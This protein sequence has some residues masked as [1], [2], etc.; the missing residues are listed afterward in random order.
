MP[1]SVS[2]IGL[3]LAAVIAAVTLGGTSIVPLG[4]PPLPPDETTLR[5]AP[6]E[7]VFFVASAGIGEPEDSSENHTDQLLANDQMHAFLSDFGTQVLSAAQQFGKR[8]QDTQ[9]IVDGSKPLVVA[10]LSR[11]MAAYIERID[12]APGK[13]PSLVA[14]L[15]VNCG[16]QKAEVSKALDAFEKMGL[17]AA[18]PGDKVDTATIAGVKLRTATLS[19]GMDVHWGFKGDYFIT[20]IGPNAA[21]DLLARIGGKGAKPRWMTA[22]EK[23]ASISRVSALR[24]LDVGRVLEVATAMPPLSEYS[25]ALEAAGVTDLASIGGVVGF[26]TKGIIERNFANFKGQPKGVFELL[27]GKP[28]AADDLK[29]VPSTAVMAVALRLDPVLVY[30]R[31]LDV[32]SKADAEGTT[33]FKS[34]ANGLAQGLGFR[35]EEDV[36]GSLGDVWTLHSTVA[37]GPNQ[38]AGTVLTVSLKNKETLTRIQSLVV[39]MAKAQGAQLPFSI[40]DAKLGNL[41]GYRVVPVESGAGSPA[42][43]IAGNRLIVGG[44]LDALKAQLAQEAGSQ[45]L[46]DVNAVASRLKTGAVMVTYQDTKAMVGQLLAMMQAF[47]PFGTTMLAQQGIKIDMPA[48]PEMKSIAPHVLPRTSTLRVMKHSIVSEAYETVPLVGRTLSL[49]PIA[50]LAISLLK[51]AIHAAHDPAT[52][53]Q[54]LPKSTPPGSAPPGSVPPGLTPAKVPEPTAKP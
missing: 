10:L 42:W 8:D 21:A 30:R 2:L 38:L 20:T 51:P 34:M 1:A 4:V 9:K 18:D 3:R 41:T 28:L 19:S 48:I 26:G 47:G 46:A 45:S 7:C 17:D 12:V 49:A 33:K 52:A 31:G 44:S 14:G 43:V 24:Y 39:T 25:E 22:L 5:A 54:P 40:A 37:G 53:G 6:P 15:I 27:S 13:E 36:L 11:P 23:Q 16:E 50:G 32:A 35:F 29:P